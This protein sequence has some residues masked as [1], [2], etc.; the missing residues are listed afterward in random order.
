MSQ[1][2]KPRVY[3]ALYFLILYFLSVGS[4]S[5][6]WAQSYIITDDINL[7]ITEALPTYKEAREETPERLLNSI[8]FQSAFYSESLQPGNSAFWH[9][10]ELDARFKDTRTRS[11][12]LVFDI[13]FL[14]ELDIYLFKQG[15]L[16]SHKSLGIKTGDDVFNQRLYVGP[17]IKVEISHGDKVT[18]L[19][20]KKNEGP[21]ILPISVKSAEHFE[22]YTH[23][24][25]MF[26]GAS[27]AV[28][29]VLALY[30]VFIYALNPGAA[31]LWY[32]L[33]HSTTFV[34]FSVLHG[35]GIW[36]WPQ[37]VHQILSQNIMPMNV[38]LVL[39]AVQFA[40][41]FLA[42]RVNAPK[43]Y[44]WLVRFRWVLIGSF[45]LAI[46][47]P[48]YYTIMPFSVLQVTGST[49]AIVMGFV[50]WKNRFRPAKYFLISMSALII[51]SIVGMLTYTNVLPA[52]FFTLHG[53]FLGALAELILLSVALA[54]RL[55][56]AEKKAIAKAYIDPQRKL[57]NYSFFI[58]EFS[59]EINKITLAHD[60]VSL[61]IVHTLNYQ[62][63]VGLLGPNILEPIYRAHVARLEKIVSIAPWSISFQM[64]SGKKEYFISLPGDQLLFLVDGHANLESVLKNLVRMSVKP[65][66]I[67][68]YQVTLDL[69]VGSADIERS[70]LSALDA[71][72]RVQ[73]ALLHCE[74]TKSAWSIYS[75]EQDQWLKRHSRLLQKLRAAI[76]D[77]QFSIELQP[78]VD[79]FTQQLVGAEVLVRWQLENEEWVPTEEFISV[80]EQ[81]GVIGHISQQVIEMAFHWLSVQ[82]NL[83]KNFRLAINLSAHD[84]DDER[85]LTFIEKQTKIYH[86]NPTQVT[87]EI[88]ESSMIKNA[89]RSLSI[90]NA[91]KDNGFAIA[92]D[93]FGTGYSSLSYLLKIKADK[94]KI[95]MSFVKNIHK[96]PTQQAI[97]K[98]VIQV[99][100]SIDA[101]IVAEGIEHA[102]EL[103]FFK[104]LNCQFGQGNFWSGPLSIDKFNQRYS[105]S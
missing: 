32:L 58:N 103:L 59:H 26:W 82:Q 4:L 91:L 73:I 87:F 84:L 28:L 31:Y 5:T 53:F 75:L 40:S 9:R 72:R 12:F 17:N 27:V 42:V 10:F 23:F 60:R 102:E 95:D 15:E 100:H 90:I 64:P 76:D 30:N 93:D 16:I 81:T 78:Q 29:L 104:S 21:T 99:G 50:A 97:V 39:I 18:V 51:G 1:K 43:L 44:P 101:Q 11:I 52:N 24:K 94:L 89:E 22:Y 38:L 96:D 74:N 33:F 45:P 86:V 6:L 48:E 65:L 68:D 98:S 105:L 13:H 63:L 83:P 41:V 37:S 80:A 71:Y 49:L 46:L 19:I 62:Q 85:T 61:V 55:R 67:N 3:G 35:F 20:R 79:L 2:M 8:R 69:Q 36:L 34:Y 56:F 54:D 92:I 25:L 66:V 7:Q 88:T 14:R 77:H 57:P 47:L 70:D